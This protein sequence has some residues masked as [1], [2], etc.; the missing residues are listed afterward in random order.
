MREELLERL[1]RISQEEREILSGSGQ[2][3][4]ELYTT[5]KYFT[6]E[7][8]K[9]LESGQLI[10][11]RTHTRFVHFP[12]HNHNFVEVS[13]VCHGEITHVIEGEP[14][15]IREGELLFLN[16][17][18][19][20]EILEAGEKDVAINFMILP[21]FFDTALG[22]V[23]PENIL[24]DFLVNALRE[25][26][27]VSQYL[28]FQV[29]ENLQIQ[30]LMENITYSLIYNQG[31]DSRVNQITM[32]LLFL[33]LLNETRNMKS[34]NSR[35]YENMIA[36]TALKYIR[37]HYRDASLGQ[38]CSML[39][40]TMPT[41]SRLISRE[42]G[43]TF[44]ELLQ[45]QRMARAAEYLVE[46]DLPVNHIVTAVGYENNSYFYRRFLECFGLTPKEYRI[47]YREKDN[48][49]K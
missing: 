31:N 17:H 4:K 15:T 1:S 2:V 8:R 10:A 9:M 12:R 45:K 37:E 13:Y 49:P 46:T 39:G 6:V 19:T 5:R 24:A 29:S 23:G 32:G 14:V 21:E 33:Y 40:Q 16:Q 48:V 22:M 7:S 47:K 43:Y 34:G 42:T 30:N 44:K 35:P 38:L 18:I 26:N 28:Y 11:V 3:R 25:K 36:M 41:L 20:H 27:G